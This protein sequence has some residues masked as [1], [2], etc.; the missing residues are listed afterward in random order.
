MWHI[1]VL[2]H[3]LLSADIGKMAHSDI[4]NFNK[5]IYKVKNLKLNQ[6]EAE[7]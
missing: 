6:N 3:Q 1:Q 5:I 2:L 4:S 7:K